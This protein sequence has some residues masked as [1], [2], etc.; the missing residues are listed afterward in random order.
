M[1]FILFN[2]SRLTSTALEPEVKISCKKKTSRSNKYSA[3]K[4]CK[5]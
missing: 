1:T 4:H 2:I 5:T 3:D